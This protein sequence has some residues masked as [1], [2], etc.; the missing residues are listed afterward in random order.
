M[1]S[2]GVNLIWT[3]NF[4]LIITIMFWYFFFLI[5]VKFYDCIFVIDGPK[6]W[7]F[8]T[9]LKYT[10]VWIHW[11]RSNSYGLRF[12]LP[13]NTSTRLLPDLHHSLSPLTASDCRGVEHWWLS[14]VTNMLSLSNGSLSMMPIKYFLHPKCNIHNFYNF[15]FLFS[16]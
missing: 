16:Y 12:F 11:V 9:C 14:S 2:S 3:D 4:R 10:E 15:Q 6:T 1:W 7:T 13:C 5:N 8:D